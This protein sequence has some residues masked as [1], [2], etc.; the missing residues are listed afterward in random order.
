MS[1]KSQCE[2]RCTCKEISLDTLSLTCVNRTEIVGA[3][4]PQWNLV[5]LQ[6]CELKTQNFTFCGISEFPIAFFSLFFVSLHA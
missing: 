4:Q 6:E 5:K 2:V 1:S 3:A